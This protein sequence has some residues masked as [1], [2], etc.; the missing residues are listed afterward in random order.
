MDSLLH[1]NK[2]RDSQGMEPD[3]AE[4]VSK[5]TKSILDNRSEFT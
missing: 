3:W 1:Y 4:Q 2:S 5:A